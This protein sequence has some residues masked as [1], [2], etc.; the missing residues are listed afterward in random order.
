MR[1]RAAFSARKTIASRK[2]A[3]ACATLSMS[4][5]ANRRR[6]GSGAHPGFHSAGLVCGILVFLLGVALLGYV[7]LTARTLFEAPAP[8]IPASPPAGSPEA[9]T[10]PPPTLVLGQ[11]L[12]H[13]LQQLLILFL[14]CVAGSLVAGQGVNMFFKALAAVPHHPPHDSGTPPPPAPPVETATISSNSN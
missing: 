8:P 5:T 4:T 3:R 9:A 6:T 13:F 7:F 1:F 14:M 12:A 11:S 2:T 10:A